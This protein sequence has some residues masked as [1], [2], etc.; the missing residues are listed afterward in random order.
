MQ[1]TCSRHAAWDP[2]TRPT[3]AQIVAS[4]QD[5][6]EA[7]ASEALLVSIEQQT[8][9]SLEVNRHQ[10]ELFS[11]FMQNVDQGFIRIAEHPALAEP[12]RHEGLS[13]TTSEHNAYFEKRSR[14]SARC[15]EGQGHLNAP[16][17]RRVLLQPPVQP[18][19]G[20]RSR[21]ATWSRSDAEG[22]EAG[23][24]NHHVGA[25]KTWFGRRISSLPELSK[26]ARF[27]VSG[28]I[29]RMSTSL[30]GL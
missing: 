10:T 14:E 4:L 3:S 28:R 6:L 2:H 22:R 20:P 27:T 18:P 21:G 15:L 19:A 13:T 5:A 12:A 26:L 7:D 11:V 30:I 24:P 8:K 17:E 1:H 9:E 16:D 29:R 25:S 23:P